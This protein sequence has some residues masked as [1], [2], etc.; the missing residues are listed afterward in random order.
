MDEIKTALENSDASENHN[1]C[2]VPVIELFHVN[3]EQKRNIDLELTRHFPERLIE[4]ILLVAPPEADSGMFEFDTAK[5]GRYWNFPDS[6]CLDQL[7]QQRDIVEAGAP[8]KLLG[9]EF[10]EPGDEA[11]GCGPLERVV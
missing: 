4:R 7:L 9:G 8:G 5:R 6:P 2:F 1:K 10:F 3:D 11:G